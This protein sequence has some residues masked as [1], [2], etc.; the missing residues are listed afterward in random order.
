MSRSLITK[1]AWFS[2]PFFF[3]LRPSTRLETRVDVCEGEGV[4]RK[5]LHQKVVRLLLYF[6]KLDHCQWAIDDQHL[7][8]NHKVMAIKSSQS[9]RWKHVSELDDG[10]KSAV[11]S[12]NV[13][14]ISLLH[15]RRAALHRCNYYRLPAFSTDDGL[16]YFVSY[17][18]ELWL[19]SWWTSLNTLIVY[20]WWDCDTDGNTRVAVTILIV[21]NL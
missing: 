19:A 13:V 10:I 12:S 8:L 17:P 2:G 1:G 21:Y 9:S 14:N 7:L 16:C 11:T 5:K 6:T 3:F 18:W 4:A 20:I 15:A